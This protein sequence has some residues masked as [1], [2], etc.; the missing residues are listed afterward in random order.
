MTSDISKHASLPGIAIQLRN[1]IGHRVSPASGK[2]EDVEAWR[3]PMISRILG[4]ASWKMLAVGIPFPNFKDLKI[5]LKR[6]Y[7]DNKSRD[8]QKLVNGSWCQH[9]PPS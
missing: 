5:S 2:L 8:D 1:I 7:Q 4:A 3:G 9:Q 6:E